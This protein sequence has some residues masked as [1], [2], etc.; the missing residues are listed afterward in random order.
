MI[1]LPF[2]L[3]EYLDPADRLGEILFGLIMA[4]GFTAAIRIGMEQTSNRA[5]L[6]GI[7][8]CNLAWGIVDGVMYVLTCVF[9]RGRT[10]RTI[11]AVQTAPDQATAIQRITNEVGVRFPWLSKAEHREQIST[12]LVEAAREANPSAVRVKLEDILGG[13]A[14]GTVI[15][16]ATLPIVIPFLI[17][18]DTNRAVGWS[19]GISLTFLFLL[20]MWWGK[21]V[22]ASGWI[23]GIALTIVGT[24]L[25]GITVA[26]GG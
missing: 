14:A 26:F 18:A 19:H 11:R 4:L 13:L 17:F 7:L 2:G 21:M 23:F 8:G 6:F 16:A 12:W 5:M 3:D 25:V 15:V 10:A 24:I 9:E 22:G 20:G 1:K